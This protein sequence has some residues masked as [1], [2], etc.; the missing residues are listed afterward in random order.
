M[1]EIRLSKLTKKYNIG[2]STIVEYLR[3]EG[4]DVE[5]NPNTRIS[6][7]YIP[8]LDKKFGEDLKAVQEANQVDIKMKEIIE[9]NSRKQKDDEE[10]EVFFG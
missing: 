4:A 1:A 8:L 7:S 5:M 6:D 9:K 3:S 2:L 10:E